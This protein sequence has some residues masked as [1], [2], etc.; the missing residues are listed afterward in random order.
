MKT[1]IKVVWKVNRPEPLADEE[2]Q[3]IARSVLNA[4]QRECD[5]F[6]A[7]GRAKGRLAKRNNYT[8]INYAE[9]VLL[10]QMVYSPRTPLSNPEFARI[11]TG[12][13]KR[14]DT[15]FFIRLGKAL[16]N[17]PAKKL[18]HGNAIHLP[19]IINQ[20]LIGYWLNPFEDL[21]PLCRLN[22]DGVA[23]VLSALHGE[24][25]SVDAVAKWKTR[26]GLKSCR[27]K[28]LQIVRRLDTILVS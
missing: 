13:A 21:P 27:G 23:D 9:D 14:N 18:E 24:I 22:I 16:S 11:I 15:R 20:H 28:K 2:K 4:V 10:A 7:A 5:K 1:N 6:T 17:K 12:A 19:P 25:C 3:I 26:L 8:K